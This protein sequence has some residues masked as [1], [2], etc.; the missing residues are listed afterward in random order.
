MNLKMNMRMN[1]NR[2]R[3]IFNP[4][5]LKAKILMLGLIFSQLAWASFTENQVRYFSGAEL[6]WYLYN[7]GIRTDLSK[8]HNLEDNV[9]SSL[10]VNNPATGSPSSGG[11]TISTVGIIA[12]CVNRHFA[13]MESLLHILP[14][15]QSLL[16]GS[17]NIKELRERYNYWYQMRW[18]LVDVQLQKKIVDHLILHI[19]GPDSVIEDYQLAPSAE[20]LRAEM[21]KKIK[22]IENQSAV[23]VL[24][25]ITLSLILRDE[26]LSY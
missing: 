17:G 24:T 10:G 25:Q 26:S 1:L 7:L 5:G 6:Q 18:S 12:E 21:Y 2:K 16:M 15:T 4:T 8:C 11:P 19:L 14:E 9:S 13:T 23:Q 3:N 22:L 20:A